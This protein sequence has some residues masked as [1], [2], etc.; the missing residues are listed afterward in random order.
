[1]CRL[2]EAVVKLMATVNLPLGLEPVGYTAGDVPA[3]VEGT[4]PQQ[5]LTKMAPCA[6]GRDALT[7]IFEDAMSYR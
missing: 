7:M 2:A 6:A 5:R 1:M 3:L 4:L